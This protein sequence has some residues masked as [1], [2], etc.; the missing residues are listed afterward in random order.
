M[1]SEWTSHLQDPK[2]KEDFERA[3][4]RARHVLNRLD[5]I[6]E[7]KMYS[8]LSHEHGV[9]QFESPAWAEKQAFIN[10]SK[11]TIQFIRTLIQDKSN[12]RYT[13]Q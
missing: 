9:K 2:E 7:M 13:R 4:H 3:V 1:Y 5:T 6:L 12:D 11:S 10:G 8:M